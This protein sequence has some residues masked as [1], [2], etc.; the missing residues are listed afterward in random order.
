MATS[1][2][3]NFTKLFEAEVKQAYQGERKLAGTTRTR[4][5]VVGSTVQFPKMAKAS[6]TSKRLTMTSAVNLLKLSARL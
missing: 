3:T 5:G 4:T 6:L 1:L 2:S